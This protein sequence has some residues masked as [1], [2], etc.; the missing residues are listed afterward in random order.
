MVDAVIGALNARKEWLYNGVSPELAKQANEFFLEGCAKFYLAQLEVLTRSQATPAIVERVCENFITLFEALAAVDGPAEKFI[1]PC[2]AVMRADLAGR[3][4][5]NKTLQLIRVTM[6]CI[7]TF[8]HEEV[9]R[10][11]RKRVEREGKNL[12]LQGI[13]SAMYIFTRSKQPLTE[14]L[15]S[16]LLLHLKKLKVELL[17][18][19]E[20]SSMVK[21]ASKA[22]ITDPVVY[23]FL[24]TAMVK[25]LKERREPLSLYSVNST[26]ER[27]LLMK[28]GN[29]EIFKGILEAVTEEMNH[30]VRKT[31]FSAAD[32]KKFEMTRLY[33]SLGM[34]QKHDVKLTVDAELI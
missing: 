18:A 16:R 14:L 17:A 23:E 34:G 26:L 12:S 7:Q 29:K 33:C 31:R 13:S 2:F 30:S 9:I 21:S 4:D 32:R 22:G 20:I 3:L 25:L 15:I 19:R 27:L 10:L 8:R 6:R 5:I 1:D 28:C 11:V 24:G